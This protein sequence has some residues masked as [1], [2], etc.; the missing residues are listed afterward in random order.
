MFAETRDETRNFFYA[1]WS[2][3][4]ASEALTPLE[5]IVADVIKKHPE[6]HKTLDTIVNS[7]LDSNQSNDY[8]NRDNPFLHMG[9]HIALVE[10]LQSDRPKGVRRV[11][12]KIIEKLA[13]ADANG[14]HDA[15]HRIMQCLSDT[16][17]SAGRSGQAPDEDV[18]LENLQKLIPKR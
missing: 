10:Q 11:Y 17:W 1:V 3:M 2:K 15:E 9:L 8:I 18:Y 4:S 6:Y 12:S 5:T 14:L 16:L 13:A 7:P